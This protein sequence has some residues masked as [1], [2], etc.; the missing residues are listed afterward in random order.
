[1]GCLSIKYVS[2]GQS[3]AETMLAAVLACL[4][5]AASVAKQLRNMQ[6]SMVLQQQ[7]Y[8]L[9]VLNEWQ[10]LVFDSR[11]SV[12]GGEEVQVAVGRPW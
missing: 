8:P 4:I 10:N 12:S 9:G 2:A 11:R 3:T 1:M 5:D 6:N 7:A